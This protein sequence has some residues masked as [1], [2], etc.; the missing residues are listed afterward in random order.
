LSSIAGCRGG[1]ERQD[2]DAEK[3][4][5]VLVEDADQIQLSGRR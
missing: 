4:F 2:D 5:V 3:Y 1:V